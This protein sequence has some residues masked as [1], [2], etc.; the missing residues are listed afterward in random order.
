MSWFSH[1]A[2]V[3][4]SDRLKHDLENEIRFHLDSRAADTREDARIAVEQGVDG[5]IVSNHG[6]RAEEPCAQRSKACPK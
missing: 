5:L 2:N 3:F 6:G 1:L 4:R